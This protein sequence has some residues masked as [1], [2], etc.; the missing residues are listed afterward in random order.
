MS[1]KAT[2]LC[3]SFSCVLDLFIE[4]L[5]VYFHQF[6]ADKEPYMAH[7]QL[8][9]AMATTRLEHLCALNIDSEPSTCRMTGIVCTIGRLFYTGNT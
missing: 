2:N 3:Y 6:K 8:H 7:Q 5:F 1:L 4:I 9:A